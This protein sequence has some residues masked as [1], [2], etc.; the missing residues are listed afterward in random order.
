MSVEK[1]VDIRLLDPRKLDAEA[2][3]VEREMIAIRKRLEAEAK[4]A[5][6]AVEKVQG[7]PSDIAQAGKDI[8]KAI[9][10]IPLGREAELKEQKR[11]SPI[12]ITPGGERPLVAGVAP[13][14]RKDA[15]RELRDRVNGLE[16]SDEAF[17][18]NLD[19]ISSSL[20]EVQKGIGDPFGLF[21]GKITAKIPSLLL[22]GGVIGT[23]VL[24]VGNIVLEK[25]KATF[26]PG[27]IN[28]IRKLTLEEAK[29]IPDID[30]LIAIRNGSVFFSSDT[31]VRQ[32]VVETSNTEALDTSSQR[33]NSISVGSDLGVG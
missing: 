24:A 8:D 30:N 25:I 5:T 18:K 27:G 3:K 12:G 28:D 2:R 20:S 6:D 14:G 16:D 32:K 19:K 33:F 17:E 10:K 21:F 1:D 11:I 15:F 29:T 13:A 4:K 7:A 31:R 26:A 22:K 23:I 9:G